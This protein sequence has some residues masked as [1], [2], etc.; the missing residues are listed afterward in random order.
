MRLSIIV[1]TARNGA[2]GLHGKLLYHLP[3]D[4]KRFK[5][6]TTGHTVLM[7]R[8]TFES[9]PKGS[10]PNRRNLVLSQKGR[11]EEFAGA[12]LFHSLNEALADCQLRAD[13]C[14]DYSDEVFVIGGAS[15]YRAALSFAD[16]LYL[17]CIDDDPCDADTFFPAYDSTYWKEIHR[18]HHEVDEKHCVP[19]D[20]VDLERK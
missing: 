16:R 4:M 18:E 11:E 5:A 20:F 13:R 19:F 9:L 14:E 7:G 2:I 8:K 6:L 17:T 12:S 15:V 10:L 1:A 3:A